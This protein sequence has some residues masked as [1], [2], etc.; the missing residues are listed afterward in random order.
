MKSHRV[1]AS[2]VALL[3]AGVLSACTTE[4]PAEE[5]G[6]HTPS[7]STTQATQTPSSTSG[8]EVADA[9]NEADSMFVQMM[10]VHHKGAIE[11]AELAVNQAD[12]TQVRSLAEEILAA[13]GPEIE[14]MT[15]WLSAW[16][17]PV[18]ATGET[19]Q[20]D[21]GGM[22]MEGMSQQ[23][24]ITELAGLSGAAF[25]T[26][27]LELMIAHHQGAVQMAE[28]VLAD[29]QNTHAQELARQIIEAQE[30]EIS[31]MQDMLGQA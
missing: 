26:R 19:G 28:D 3:L 18:M 30:A 15:S 27:F 8:G 7:D 24:V 5:G 16:E 9:H 20:M 2:C 31:Q 6:S 17:V 29:G 22:Q 10:I 1:I 12:S 13:Q 4:Q 14:T 21:H 11:M 25:D 23:E